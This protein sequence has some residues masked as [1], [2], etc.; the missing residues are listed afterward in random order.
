MKNFVFDPHADSPKPSKKWLSKDKKKLIDELNNLIL[1]KFDGS[2]LVIN[3]KISGEVIIR[4]ENPLNAAQRGD[5]LFHLEFF[6][7]DN[8]DSAIYVT[9]EPMGD[10]NSLRNLRGIKITRSTQ[11]S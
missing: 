3:A 1:S 11:E 2:C 10:K 6:L 8:Y 7:K 9:V 5:F 4:L